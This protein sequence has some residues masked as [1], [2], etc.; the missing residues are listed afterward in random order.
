MKPRHLGYIPIQLIQWT[1]QHHLE[2][3]L[4]VYVGLKYHS[5]HG[6]VKSSKAELNRY[7]ELL[8]VHPRTL[9]RHIKRL[10]ALKWI[11]KDKRGTIFIR[12]YKRLETLTGQRFRSRVEV[13]TQYL[14][15]GTFKG[16]LMGAVISYFAKLQKAK[17]YRAGLRFRN[18]AQPRNSLRPFS[19]RYLQRMT[20]LSFSELVK[21]I[22]EAEKQKFI[23]K[24]SGLKKT[25]RSPDELPSLRRGH[26]PGEPY[27]VLIKGKVYL[28]DATRFAGN[29]SFKR[30]RATGQNKSE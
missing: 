21:R 28:N 18:S 11:S 8:Q 30:F 23:V 5:E 27:P 20:K 17:A 4:R 24:Q 25:D 13:H 2:N 1:N 9:Q 14:S 26:Q 10:E 6:T 7:A 12:G 22:A 15:E 16:Y 3:A 19:L 29:L